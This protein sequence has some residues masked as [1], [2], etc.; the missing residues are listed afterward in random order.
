MADDNIAL[1]CVEAEH[2]RRKSVVGDQM[3]LRNVPEEP[4]LHLQGGV[5]VPMWVNLMLVVKNAA[6]GQSP[7]Q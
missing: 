4:D 2:K 6:S 7:L 5:Y 3:G 1:A